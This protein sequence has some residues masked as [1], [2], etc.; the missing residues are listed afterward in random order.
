VRVLLTATSV[1]RSAISA[2]G[3]DNEFNDPLDEITTTWD[4]GTTVPLNDNSYTTDPTVRTPPFWAIGTS[5]A[6]AHVSA[7]RL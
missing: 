3:G 6:A 4:S 2:P 1:R 5:H 7:L